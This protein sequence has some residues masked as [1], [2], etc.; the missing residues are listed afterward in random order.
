MN[1]SSTSDGQSIAYALDGPEGS[2][3]IVLANSLGTDLRLWGPQ[4]ATFSR[5]FRVLRFDT[6][7]HGGSSVPEGDYSLGRLGADVLDLLDAL[8]LE[9]VAFCGV[10]LGGMVGQW[11]AV[12]VPER[13]TALALCNTS[14]FMGPAQGWHDRI[15]TVRAEGMGAI[16][17]A[18]VDRWFTK[19]FRDSAARPV[20]DARAMLLKT[21]AT[22]Y[23]GCCAAIRDMD[24]RHALPS[25]GVP[26]LV[27]G[28]T[29]DPATPPG[30]AELLAASIENARLV[31]LEAAH[32]SNLE[33][34]AEFSAVLDAFLSEKA[35][36]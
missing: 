25:I 21:P 20:A 1:V 22:G 32:L 5:A 33:R 26:T 30:H 23:A 31:M 16:A 14:A 7:G 15:A 10:S 29:L 11:L 27:I 9:R 34:P 2:P 3:T 24:M 12:N 18:V 35:T 8:D 19:P 6:R 4:V 17:D 36:L 13:L 28:G